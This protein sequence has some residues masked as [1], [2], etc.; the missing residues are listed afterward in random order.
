MDDA[1]DIAAGLLRTGNLAGALSALQADVRRAPHD[2]R[3][4]VFLF[5]LFAI[6]GEWDRAR[7][8][9]AVAA[10]LNA[11]CLLLAQAYGAVVAS[12]Q[13]R[14][15]VFAGNV[16]PSCL[17]EP[18]AWLLELAQALV[19]DAAGE[20]STAAALRRSALSSAP[21][22]PGTLSGV[23]FAWIADADGRLGPVFE[24][25]LHGRYFWV[26]M[27]RVRSLKAQAV[28]DLR[29][30]VW[31]PVEVTWTDGHASAGFMPTRYPRTAEFGDARLALSQTTAWPTSSGGGTA[32][33][34]GQRM[35]TTDLDDYG[36]LE[37]RSIT[38]ALSE[39][40]AGHG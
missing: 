30:L 34:A 24:L 11:G 22:I 39:E 36:L 5:Q 15:R 4:R 40:H 1:T 13:R 38:F 10:D 23:P 3:L 21:A 37:H 8:Q 17:G 18:P 33:G 29:D 25:M 7:R 20:P 2:A 9:L 6:I 12:E 27:A 14:E 26:P 32:I 28:H 35:W 19:A 16:A 31:L